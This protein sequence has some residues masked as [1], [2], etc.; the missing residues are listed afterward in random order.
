MEHIKITPKSI[1]LSKTISFSDLI[2][3]VFLANTTLVY[4][5]PIQILLQVSHQ[6]R[7]QLSFV[8]QQRRGAQLLISCIISFVPWEC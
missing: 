1:Y 3:G 6:R 4:S 8:H 2:I 7:N 5:I